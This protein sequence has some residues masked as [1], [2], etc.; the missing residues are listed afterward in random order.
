MQS[1]WDDKQLCFQNL[2]M[3][4]LVTRFKKLDEMYF[5]RYITERYVYVVIEVIGLLCIL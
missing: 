5:L 3:N 1:I 2:N 4:I